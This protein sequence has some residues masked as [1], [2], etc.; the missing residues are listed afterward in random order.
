CP[1]RSVKMKGTWFLPGSPIFR[2]RTANPVS[3]RIRIEP[4]LER[5]TRTEI[6]PTKN[7]MPEIPAGSAS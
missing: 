3:E 5:V 1:V 6:F 2:P 7:G 4:I